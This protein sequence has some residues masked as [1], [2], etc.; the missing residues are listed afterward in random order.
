ML[1]LVLMM[2]LLC[3]YADLVGILGGL[4][5]SQGFGISATEYVIQTMNAVR[6]HD[7]AVGLLIITLDG[8]FAVITDA[9]GF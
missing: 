9:I 1:A 3:L 2:P 7:F 6:L 8:I 5:V 4:V